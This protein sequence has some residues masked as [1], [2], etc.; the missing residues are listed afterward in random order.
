MDERV[1]PG[2]SPGRDDVADE[3]RVIAYRM[4][5]HE[6]AFDPTEGPLE[7]RRADLSLLRLDPCPEPNRRH[8][9]CEMLREVFLSRGED[10]DG[11]RARLADELVKRRVAA[12]RDSDKRRVQG[13]RDERVDR[14][15]GRLAAPVDRDDADRCGD[16]PQQGSQLLV[17]HRP[18]LR[19]CRRSIGSGAARAVVLS[20]SRTLK[21]LC[22]TSNTKLSKRQQ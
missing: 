11:E 10:A 3:E 9:A 18:M 17:D 5:G 14:Q 15:P 4:L 19:A 7:Q 1:P 2:A 21:N 8:S 16:V 22:K 13:E 6:P 12:E 20:D